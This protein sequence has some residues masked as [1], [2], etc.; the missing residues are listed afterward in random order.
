MG[1]VVAGGQKTSFCL[2]DVAPFDLTLPNAAQEPSGFGCGTVQRISVGW[3]D[4]YDALTIGQQI[5]VSG[6]APGQYWLEAVVDPDN[7]LLESNENNNTGRALVSVGLGG[8]D[9]PFGAHGVQLSSGQVVTKKDFANFRTISI[10]GQVFNDKNANGRQDNKEHGLDGWTVFID[11]NGDGVLNNPEGNGLPTALA[12]E[13]WAI[14][15]N[16]GKYVFA[17]HGPGINRLLVVPKAGWTQTTPNPAPFGAHS[18]QNVPGVNFGLIQASALTAGQTGGGATGTLTTD[19]VTPLLAQALAR[20]QAA[21]VD[22]SVLGAVDVRITD[23]GGATLGLASG[24]TIWLDDNAAGWGWFVDPTPWD[25]SEFTTPGNQGEQN[26]MDLLTVLEHEVGHLLGYD[27][28]DGGVMADTLA[29]G[30]RRAPAAGGAI[31]WFG[32]LDGLF[33]YSSRR[34]SGKGHGGLCH[35]DPICK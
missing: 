21:G 16:Q 23:L 30:V 18:G 19:Q 17:G 35:R 5:D 15:D 31:D 3:E 13:P 4:I 26:R 2:V 7:R 14:T 24:N 12:K 34:S 9:A 11:L 22:T 29:A 1:A 33:A 28:E 20:W 8:P 32:A 25:D 10:S 6:L 27:H